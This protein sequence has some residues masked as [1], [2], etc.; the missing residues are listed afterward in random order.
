MDDIASSSEVVVVVGL[1]LED[2]DEAEEEQP[3]S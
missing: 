2:V 1:E 3:G